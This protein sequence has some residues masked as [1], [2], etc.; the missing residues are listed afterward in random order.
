ML[1][2]VSCICPTFARVELLNEA[3]QSFLLQDYEGETELVVVNDFH[4][5]TLVFD[6]PQVNVINLS[7]RAPT[8]GE[9]WHTGYS[10]A[11]GE[12]LITW[13]DD[14]I[15]LPH[16]IS[17][18]MSYLAD[19]D[20]AFEGWYYALVHDGLFLE[21]RSTAGAMAV[22]ANAYHAWGGI[23]ALNVGEDVAFNEV[24]KK[25]M[26]PKTIRCCQEEPGFLYRWHGTKR[27]HISGT[28]SPDPYQ[29]ILEQAEFLVSRGE[30]P[31]GV[32]ELKPKWLENY[33][34]KVKEAKLR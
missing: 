18:M 23:P 11:T 4:R 2:S 14:D 26:F 22:K 15:H 17:R 5:Q 16:R 20:M 7:K 25:A 28:S 3:V 24:A 31:S 27:R 1:P 13:G 34:E 29:H 32:V 8:L 30:E 6:H 12:V 10:Q 9:K 19:D 33:V 21:R